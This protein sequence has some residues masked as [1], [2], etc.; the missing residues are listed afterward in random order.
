VWWGSAVQYSAASGYSDSA[1]MEGAAFTLCVC[2]QIPCVLLCSRVSVACIR[3]VEEITH[4]A[5]F[6]L[7]CRSL[8]NRQQPKAVLTCA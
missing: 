5:T 1:R 2:A 3:V 8:Y 7:A 6:S 4:K